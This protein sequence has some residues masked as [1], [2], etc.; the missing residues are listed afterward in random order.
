MGV[1]MHLNIFIFATI[2]CMLLVSVSSKATHIVGNKIGWNIPSYP[3][4]FADWAKD[5]TFVVGDFLQ[6]GNMAVFVYHPGL[7]TVVQVDKN[8]Y[9]NC[10]TR[11]TIYTYFK[12][13]S[14]VPLEKPGDYFF[15]SSVGKHCE[16]G[17]KLWINVVPQGQTS[18]R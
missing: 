17:Q 3:G 1:K 13:N 14:S 2:I 6:D 16:A 9:D 15:F 7:N 18:S 4:F 5:R 11:N 8:G 10:S 12:G